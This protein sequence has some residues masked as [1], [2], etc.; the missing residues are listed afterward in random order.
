MVYQQK[1]DKEVDWSEVRVTDWNEIIFHTG[2]NRK[3]KEWGGGGRRRLEWRYTEV[4]SVIKWSDLRQ[5][6]YH[7]EER[8]LLH[9]S[10]PV[11]LRGSR[12]GWF[13]CGGYSRVPSKEEEHRVE[14]FLQ[15]PQAEP[16]ESMPSAAQWATWR[17]DPVVQIFL[18]GLPCFTGGF[19]QG[20]W[21]SEAAV[22]SGAH[23]LSA[24]PRWPKT[25]LH[26]RL[27]VH[28]LRPPVC[29]FSFGGGW[30]LL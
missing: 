1:R 2:K 4:T 6:H 23:F 5:Y 20:E 12:I 16:C 13:G 21:S 19:R 30:S 14:K 26:M 17:L 15:R 29:K 10:G 25:H 28:Q 8:W 9:D 22:R 24:P 18:A 7:W 27:S 3:G 11:L